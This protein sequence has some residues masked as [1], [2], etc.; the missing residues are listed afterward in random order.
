MKTVDYNEL[1]KMIEPGYRHPVLVCVQDKDIFEKEHIPGSVHLENERIEEIAPN[2]FSKHDWIVL[3]GSDRQDQSQQR[4]ADLLEKAGYENTFTYDGGLDDWKKHNQYTAH[5]VEE[6]PM[7]RNM[8]ARGSETKRGNVVQRTE[9]SD[10]ENKRRREE[11]EEENKY[12]GME[13]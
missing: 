13:E 3:Y 7:K 2:L 4:A 6:N 9:E 11:E 10:E 8:N 1:T 12:D 5:E